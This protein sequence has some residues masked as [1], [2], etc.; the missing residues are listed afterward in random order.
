MIN[1]IL[2]N[3]KRVIALFALRPFDMSTPEGRAQERHRRVALSTLAS[4]A[5]KIISVGTALIS[6]PL[7]LN[8]LGA[9]RYGMWMTMSSLVAML[10]FADFGIG[11]G[12]VNAVAN[13]HGRDQIVE[14]RNYI[15][16][17][18]FVL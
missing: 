5:A 8:Y 16:S 11:N 14:I 17:G 1:R 2:N 6:V 10:S 7:A 13:A 12:V 15:S 9:E 3:S 18:F 4:V